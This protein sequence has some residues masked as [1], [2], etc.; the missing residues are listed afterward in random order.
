MPATR[1]RTRNK[2]AAKNAEAKQNDNISC[3]NGSKAKVGDQGELVL[4]ETLD[5]IP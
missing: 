1:S 4:G 3:N 2:T 5:R